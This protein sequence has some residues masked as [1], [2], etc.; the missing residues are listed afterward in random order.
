MILSRDM[1]YEMLTSVEGVM[2]KISM[3]RQEFLLRQE[4]KPLSKNDKIYLRI[5]E[6]SFEELRSLKRLTINRMKLSTLRV[7]K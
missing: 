4:E 6:N 1:C 2:I 7:C 3:T 5:L